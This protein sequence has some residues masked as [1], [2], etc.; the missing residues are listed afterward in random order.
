MKM[1]GST[2]ALLH[3]CAL[4]GF[5]RGPARAGGR[6]ERPRG[7]GV[8][9]R[10]TRDWRSKALRLRAKGM[11]LT[12]IARRCDVTVQAVS[13]LLKNLAYREEIHVFRIVVPGGEP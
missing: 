7:D 11:L 10:G 5:G 3:D 6:I 2:P 8:P 13:L 12:D 4:A 9:R 1:A